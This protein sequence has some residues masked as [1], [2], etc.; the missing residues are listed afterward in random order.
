[1]TN[2]LSMAPDQHHLLQAVYD[3]F[4]ADGAW[5]AFITVDR[6]LR[7]QGMDTGAVAQAIPQSLLLRP[8]PGTYRPNPNDLVRLTIRGIAACDGS[9]DD[10]DHFVRLLR[11]LAEKEIEFE[12]TT[13]ADETMP[14]LTSAEIRDHLDLGET[15][16]CP[17]RRLYAMLQL[18]HWGLGGSGGTP[19]DW[20][21]HVGPDIWRYR[22]VQTAEDCAAA[23]ENW[24]REGSPFDA[25]VLEE[26]QP[27][28]LWPDAESPISEPDETVPD[29]SYYH[30]RISTGSNPRDEVR[31]DLSRDELTSR[32]LEPY[33]VGRP[34]VVGGRTIPISDLIKIRISRTEQPSTELRPI[35]QAE[36]RRQAVSSPLS[37]DWLIARAGEDVTDSF[38]TEPPGQSAVTAAAALPAVL[39]RRAVPYVAEKL[40]ASIQAKVEVSQLDCTKLLQ[41]IDELNDNYAR[42]NAYA[43]HALL[44]AILDHIPPILGC[45]SIT[46]VANNYQWS[47]TDRGYVKRLLDFKPQ[48]DDV[49][50]R[51]ISGKAD[52]LGMDDLPPRVWLNRLLQE[53]AAKL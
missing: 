49:L 53:C 31:L 12:P 6:P 23:R 48:G 41:L 2:D 4:R 35:V 28:G 7:R 34:I 45:A 16:T 33:R 43:A 18:D 17:L 5:P 19:D 52:L 15:D 47:R 22:D 10:I 20:F 9:D 25:S 1:V 44:R 46:E 40:T 51:Q 13:G 24:R 8:M 3:R 50:H 32:F 21:V 36:R 26:A 14:R 27:D 38:I 29:V 39:A 30:A 11:W 42:E 37:E